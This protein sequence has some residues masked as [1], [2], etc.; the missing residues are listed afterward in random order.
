MTKATGMNVVAILGAPDP[1]MAAIE[2]LLREVGV[3]VLYGAGRPKPGQP[4]V[5]VTPRE[6][7]DVWSVLGDP[8]VL[9]KGT[10]ALLV[11]CEIAD[12]RLENL[13]PPWR[14]VRADHHSP[15]DPGYGRPP[16]DYLAASSLGQV[17]GFLAARG[18]LPASWE[19]A[20]GLRTL[21][22]AIDSH[23][24]LWYVSR[25]NP[26]GV[27]SHGWRVPPEVLLTAAA[28]HCL[29]AA[30]AGKCPGVAPA[31][32][33]EHR[34]AE[35]GKWLATGV[36]EVA[37]RG[38]AWVVPVPG[39]PRGQ[40]CSDGCPSHDD[41]NCMDCAAQDGLEELD[42]GGAPL[43]A[44]AVTR[45]IAWTTAVVRKAPVI[46]LGGVAVRDLRTFGFLPEL[47][48][49]LTQMGECG[50]YRMEPR[51]GARDPRP[52]VGVTGAG[53]GSVPGTAPVEAFLGGWGA[54]QGLEGLYPDHDG[55]PAG[56]RAAAVRGFAG[57]YVSD[58]EL[59]APRT[60]RT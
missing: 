40:G 59:T 32:L 34:A 50:L 46:D 23:R 4:P 1:E 16:G 30:Y 36:D 9:Q 42:R 48:A 52:C 10:T 41:R 18:R 60:G 2:G 31:E 14:V 55:T 20:C 25:G 24:G 58:D 21:P 37:R 51:L 35:R 29:A 27:A 53:E 12:G 54:A 44:A 22:G 43:W 11:E 33:A 57:G 3:P 15:G 13:P 17:V 19:V 28:D 8:N 49:A 47:P 5:R 6:A 39:A 7:G 56:I 26:G 45:A 38:I